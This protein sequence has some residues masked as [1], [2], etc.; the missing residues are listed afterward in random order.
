MAR[1]RIILGTEYFPDWRVGRPLALADIYIGDVDLDPEVLANRK[2]V[3]V[4]QEDGTEVSIPPASQPLVTG[5][6]GTVLYLGAPVQLQTDDAYSIKILDSTGAQVYYFNSVIDEFPDTLPILQPANFYNNDISSASNAYAIVPPVTP[7]PD[8]LLDDQVLMFRPSDDSSGACTINVLGDSGFIGPKQWLLPDGTNQ[9]PSGY[10]RTTRDYM[11]RYKASIDSFIDMDMGLWSNNPSIQVWNQYIDYNT[12]PSYVTGSDDNLYK[13]TTTSGPNLGGDADPVGDT[14]GTWVQVLTSADPAINDFRLTLTSG[15]PV[16]TGNTGDSTNIYLCP[17]AGN[18]LSLYNGFAWQT[19]TSAQV[20]LAL[21]AVTNAIG[22]DVFGYINAGAIAIEKLA[23]ASATARATALTYQDGVLVKSGDATRRYL[24]SFYTTSVTA[25]SSNPLQGVVPTRGAYVWNY[26]NRVTQS[27]QSPLT[28]T[29]HAYT[30]AT[31]RDI[32]AAAGNHLLFFIGVVE[33]RV[34]VSLVTAA[35]NSSSNVP[36]GI[37]YGVNTTTAPSGATAFASGAG[38]I[39]QS[40]SI[41]DSFI[42][43]LGQN[44]IAPLQYSDASGTTTWHTVSA[45]YFSGFTITY[46]S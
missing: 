15:T 4:I 16:T 20:T 42:P 37:G 36:R 21:G 25:T 44:D 18:K 28:G 46:T 8:V 30:T 2:T 31:W 19:L 34:R 32:E 39:V 27:I 1:S 38:N 24:G 41:G 6:G 35:A 33:E 5:A 11:V 29:T 17:Y 14:T 9:L 10:V 22:Y 13:S 7:Y 12:T 3:Y 26:Y 40:M 23:W 45:P 43:R